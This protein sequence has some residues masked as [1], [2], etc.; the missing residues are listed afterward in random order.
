MCNVVKHYLLAASILYSHWQH[1]DALTTV[2][3]ALWC[4]KVSCRAGAASPVRS[5]VNGLWFCCG[6]IMG[7]FLA[8]AGLL[9][10][11]FRLNTAAAFW[12]CLTVMTTTLNTWAFTHIDCSLLVFLAAPFSHFLRPFPVTFHLLAGTPV[13]YFLLLHLSTGSSP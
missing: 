7:L 6:I 10:P 5:A 1:E 8:R 12:H 2:I 11:L 3:V 13:S 9:W 4:F